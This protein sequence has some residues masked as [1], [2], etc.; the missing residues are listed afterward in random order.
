MPLNKCFGLLAVL[1]FSASVLCHNIHGSNDDYPN[2]GPPASYF[3]AAPTMPVAALQSAASRLGRT[4]RG[5]SFRVSSDS[6]ERSSIYSDWA[7]FNEG[8]AVV[9]TADM[10]VDC[11]GIDYECKGNP[12][13]LPETTW[14]ALAAYEVP[15]IVM[16]EHYLDKHQAGLPGNNIAAVICNGKMFYS[17][18]GDTNGDSPEVTGEASW[19]MARTCFPTEDLSGDTGHNDPDITYIVFLG[20]DAVLPASAMNERY[21]TD[22]GTLRSKGDALVN[23]LLRNIGLGSGNGRRARKRARNPSFQPVAPATNPRSTASFLTARWITTS[24]LLEPSTVPSSAASSNL[25]SESSAS[26]SFAGA[27]V[28][29]TAASFPS[30]S[31]PSIAT[32]SSS[33]CVATSNPASA[34]S[35]GVRASPP[36]TASGVSAASSAAT[37]SSVP[38]AGVASNA[39]A[40]NTPS[41]SITSPNTPA[42]SVATSTARVQG[43]IPSSASPSAAA[44]NAA[45][46]PSSAAASAPTPTGSS[47]GAPSST[48]PPASATVSSATAGPTGAA[49]S[50]STPTTGFASAASPSAAV[51]IAPPTAAAGAASAPSTASPAGPASPSA[52]SPTSA[53]SPP[54]VAAPNP[55][56]H[57]SATTSSAAASGAAS[58]SASTPSCSWPGHCLGAPCSTLDDCSDDLI[59]VSGLCAVDQGGMG[60][61]ASAT[62]TLTARRW[63]TTVRG[64]RRL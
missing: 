60:S 64:D 28:S 24:R 26:P 49:V 30:V 8:A 11:D 61:A 5:S 12:D 7:S 2:G 55:A 58:P 1:F 40:P 52:A 42:A 37:P 57:P 63:I 31:S 36:V 33:S 25:A 20:G 19:L 48:P 16:P 56:I 21:I 29:T 32:P 59:C 47:G 17:I 39:A 44:S 13:G 45:A 3:R 53:A 23:A 62:G 46:G 35:A 10:D 14:G 15:F 22:F 27:G 50:V 4:Y 9:W 34:D 54:A 6:S 43:S 51:P 38:P 41:P 18:L